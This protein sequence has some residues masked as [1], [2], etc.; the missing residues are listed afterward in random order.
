MKVSEGDILNAH[1]YRLDNCFLVLKTELS[2]NN[3]MMF[4]GQFS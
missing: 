3:E 4:S 1:R 2:E